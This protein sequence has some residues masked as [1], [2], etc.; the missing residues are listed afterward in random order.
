M[1]EN[2]PR[3]TVPLMVLAGG[4]LVAGFTNIPNTGALSWVPDSFALRFE[5]FVEPTGRYFPGE[6]P[7]FAHPEFS[8][9]LALISTAVGLLG[10]LGA[11]LWFWRGLGPQGLTER[12]R[13]ARG[14]YK[15]LENKYGL[16]V[17]YTDWIAGATKGPIA[18]AAN[19]VNQN[20]LDGVVNAVGNGARLAGG[21]V[22]KRIDQGVVDTI[23]TGS[24]MAAEGSG[25]VLRKSQTGKVQAYGA[26]LFLGAT[27][28]AAVF[29]LIAS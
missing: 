22:Y 7:A 27:I 16:D 10:V 3:I 26:Y 23:V 25:E 29:V 21:W 1:H 20:V 28:L 8:I 2:G 11:Y 18:R 19:W 17:L 4:A 5:H 13:F 6:L 15:V 14:A 9:G 12:N 24:G